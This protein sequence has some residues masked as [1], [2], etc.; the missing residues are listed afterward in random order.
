MKYI[1]ILSCAFVILMSVSCFKDLNTVPLDEDVVT[2]AVVFDDPNS[3]LQVLAKLYAG[4][5]VSGQ[6]GPAGQADIEGIDEGFGQYLRGYWYHQELTTDEALIGWNDQTIGDYHDQD[7]TSADGFTFAHYSR[8]F[9]QIALANEYLRETTDEKLSSR[10]VDAG[11]KADIQGFRAEARFLRALSYTHALDLFRNVPFVTEEDIVGS[12]FPDQIKGAD[13]FA[14]IE[15]ELKD[16]ETKIAPVRTNPYGRADQGAVWMLM[17]KLYLNAEV[18]TGT[19]KYTECLEYCKKILN[20]GYELE[21]EYEYLFLADNHLSKGIIF[22]ITYD[23]IHTRTW[24]GTT[25]IV[26]AGIGG[27]MNPEDSGVSGGWGGVRT[28]KE[29]VQKFPDADKVLVSPNEGKTK[30]YPKVYVPGSFND[31]DASDTDNSLASVASDNVFEGYKYF[32]EAGTQ[33]V[34][35][36]IPSLALKFGDNEGDGILEQNGADIIAGEAGLY[37]F[38]VNMNDKTYRLERRDFGILGDATSAG[39]DGDD[40]N[41][42][43]DEELGGLKATLT[44]NAGEFKFRAND[45]F[46][47]NLGDDLGDGILTQDGGNIIIEKGGNYEIILFIDK[48]D[49]TY[50]INFLDF[51]RRKLFYTE[52]QS[53]E[54]NDISLF[55][56]G[57]AINKF[58]NINRDGSRGSDAAH[59]DTDF[60]MFRLADVYLMAAESILRGASGGSMDEALQYVNAVRTRAFQGE[61]AN[62]SLDEL[63]LDFLIDERARELYWECHRRTDLIRFGKFSDTDYTWAWKGGVKEGKAV[64]SFRDIFPIPSSDISGNP[65]L[66][67][68]PGY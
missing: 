18:Y 20:A 6:Q 43:W 37:Y 49:Y 13:L 52:G 32:P 55:T 61:S 17:A 28:T 27:S 65:S 62:I 44:L 54:I 46:A 23:G 57:Y 58:K 60:I 39:W 36:T 7:W 50:Q 8:I 1:K 5:A 47:V 40:I 53:L 9:Y 64:E 26:S 33:F 10:G 59:P 16:I 35:T 21:P 67:Q 14:F 31:F 45:D 22:P 38:N 25:F 19:G 63:T 51:D 29:F 12:F 66:T 24:G 30:S 3:Y 41:M 34:F 11:L 15:S 4:L 68:N 2:A 42:E 48:P 56:D